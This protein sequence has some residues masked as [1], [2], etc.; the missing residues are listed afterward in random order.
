MSDEVRLLATTSAAPVGP[1]GDHPSAGDE[2]HNPLDATRVLEGARSP[3]VPNAVGQSA[4][5][6]ARRQFLGQL[7]GSCAAC[8]LGGMGSGVAEGAP[9]LRQDPAA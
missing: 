6:P 9:A 2:L 3:R 4:T 1:R 8:A 5:A 7:V